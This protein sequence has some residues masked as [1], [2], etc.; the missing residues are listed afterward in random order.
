MGDHVIPFGEDHMVFVAE[1][2]GKVANEIEQAVAAWRNMG[3]VL[4]IV[5]RPE[6]RCLFVVT[7]VEKRLE[8]LENDRLVLSGSPHRNHLSAVDELLGKRAPA[9]Y[10]ALSTSVF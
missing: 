1:R 6:G 8:G 2:F 7:L 4:N 9:S 3:A 5:G 10:A